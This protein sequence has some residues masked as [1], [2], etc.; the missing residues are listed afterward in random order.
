MGTVRPGV[1]K[2]SA[3]V[4][5]H[6]EIIRENIRIP[7]K[8][9]RTRVLEVIHEISGSKVDLEGA[10]IIVAGGR[11]VGGAAGFALIRELAAAL[12]GEVGA[13]RPAVDAGWIPHAHQV[14]QT[15][16]TVAPKLY[17]ACGI[18]GAIQHTAGMSGAE[19]VVAI[20]SDPEAPIFSVADYGIVG[21]VFEVLPEL[22]R[23]VKLLKKD[24]FVRP[25]ETVPP[26]MPSWLDKQPWV[27]HIDLTPPKHA[28]QQFARD[29]ETF[30]NKYEDF[31]GD[32]FIA[33]ITDNAMAKMAFQGTELID[34]LGLSV[35]PDNVLIHLN[36]FHRKEDLDRILAD[37]T[38]MGLHNIL[39]VTGDGSDKMHKLLPEELEATEVT[40]TTSVEL[41][42][43]IRKHYPDLIIGAAFNNYEPPESE[44]A[45]LDRKIAAGVS[46]VITQPILGKDEQ[47]DRLLREYPDL[48]VVTEV[49]MSPKLSLLSDIIG[50]EIPDDYPYDPF[51][52]LKTVRELY[53]QCGNYLGMLSYKYQY[54]VIKEKLL[55]KE[56]F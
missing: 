46:Y 2:K 55:N 53:P 21:D 35:R 16:K 5:G 24:K 36:T 18:S 1:F 19:T 8:E 10:E 22:I 25:T 28:S 40:A 41:I 27:Y 56:P 34:T 52:T 29:L 32:G 14:G 54:P 23:E 49:W 7:Q 13:S 51:E 37:A 50:R 3:P 43:Y 11:G 44:F 6:A 12:G 20:N 48:P 45:K 4:P 17:I 38:R 9:I 26:R 42:R 31:T 33:S 47:I 39:A 30:R 15:G